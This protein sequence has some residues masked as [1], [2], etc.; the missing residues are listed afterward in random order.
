[1]T[2]SPITRREAVSRLAVGTAGLSLGCSLG[3]PLVLPPGE[4]GRLAAR[5]KTDAGDAVAGLTPLLLQPGRDGVV[6]VPPNLPPGTPAPLI[7]LLH[8]AGGS[9]RPLE[10][11]MQSIADDTGCVLLVPD[12]RGRTW[13]VVSG[14]YGA[15]V[16]FIDDAL[17]VTFA[18]FSVD[19]ERLAIAG[20]SDGAS[21]ALG[22]GCVNGNL[23]K[24]IIAFSPGFLP[25]GSPEG[26]PPVYITHGT[27]D[28]ILPLEQ[29]SRVIVEYLSAA[30]YAVDFHEFAGGHVIPST[31]A[32]EAFST[33][34]GT[35][36][37]DSIPFPHDT[38]GRS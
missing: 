22:L 9:A 21:Y 4:D 15:D 35:P 25:A 34:S 38:A 6:Y 1:M 36:V 26:K 18:K 16:R 2:P 12:S 24:R 13:D 3:D 32:R 23:F 30:G 37:A 8:G 17:S 14:E 11:A 33:V 7:L 31:L 20:F 29:T 19:A 28:T 27:N 10:S 5:P